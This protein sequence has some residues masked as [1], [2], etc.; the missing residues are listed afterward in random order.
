LVCPDACAI[1][2][3]GPAAAPDRALPLPPGGSS[4]P[5][6]ATSNVKPVRPECHDHRWRRPALIVLRVSRRPPAETSFARKALIR[7]RVL[8]S[9]RP[10]RSSRALRRRGSGR[11]RGCAS[12]PNH[13]RIGGRV[14]NESDHPVLRARLERAGLTDGPATPSDRLATRLVRPSGALMKRVCNWILRRR[15]GQ[16]RIPTMSGLR[17]QLRRTAAAASLELGRGRASATPWRPCCQ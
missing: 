4:R 6:I 2:A 8:S 10:R 15:T 5:A 14:R 17:A 7:W 9:S 12:S 11:P 13:S 16:R 1:H 3:T